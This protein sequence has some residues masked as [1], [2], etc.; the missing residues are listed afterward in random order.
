MLP[1]HVQ[2][3]QSLESS[4]KDDYSATHIHIRISL[5]QAADFQ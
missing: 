1:R 4:S 3:G 2:D 5:T